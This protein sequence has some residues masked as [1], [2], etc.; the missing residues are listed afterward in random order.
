MDSMESRKK[1][2]GA[3][4]LSNKRKVELEKSA[5]KC[6]KLD[7]FCIG[8]LTKTLDQHSHEKKGPSLS[9]SHCKTIST[10]ENIESKN[11][12]L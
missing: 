7:S 10:A 12:N 3:E 5:K 2:G 6:K 1:M 9:T 8:K 11:L 4:R